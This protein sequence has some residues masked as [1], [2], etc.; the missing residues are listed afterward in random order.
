MTTRPVKG[1]KMPDMRRVY[2]ITAGLL[3]VSTVLQ[4]YFAAVGAFAKPQEDS[5]FAAHDINGSM[6]MP[7]LTIL[8][9][10]FAALAKAPGRLIGLTALPLGL[11][12]VQVL[13]VLLG[14]ALNDSSDNTTTAGVIVLGLHALNALAILGV[15]GR[16]LMGARR[17]ATAP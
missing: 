10:I 3:V 15:T 11:V 1:G 4:F 7:L 14:R 17:L 6:V 5:S 9:V 8:A 16:V 2:L 12:V 13:I